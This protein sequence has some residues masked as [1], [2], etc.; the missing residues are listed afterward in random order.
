MNVEQQEEKDFFW[1]YIGSLAVV[2]IAVVLIVKKSENEK[3]AP[4][5]ELINEE[6]ASMN[7]RVV[8]Q[9]YEL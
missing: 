5:K 2:L 1:V 6:N 4:I 9:D 8:K 7:I 3:F